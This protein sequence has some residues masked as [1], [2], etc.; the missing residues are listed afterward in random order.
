MLY[1]W[2]FVLIFILSIM[3]VTSLA[4]FV[5]PLEDLRHNWGTVFICF[6]FCASESS[7]I[8]SEGVEGIFIVTYKYD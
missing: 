3:L 7:A 1:H 5:L 8:D 4:S 6:I 2:Y